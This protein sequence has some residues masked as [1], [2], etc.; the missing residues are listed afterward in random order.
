MTRVVFLSI[1]GLSGCWAGLPTNYRIA[2]IQGYTGAPPA[3][4]KLQLLAAA[5]EISD[6]YSQISNNNLTLDIVVSSIDTG[7]TVD[8]FY[9]IDSNGSA[10][11]VPTEQI[12]LG[13]LTFGAFLKDHIDF[14]AVDGIAIVNSFCSGDYAAPP[15]ALFSL[16][17]AGTYEVAHLFECA[18]DPHLTAQGPSGVF[19]GP[20]AHEIGHMLEFRSGSMMGGAWNGHPSE[21]ASGYALMD[22]SYPSSPSAYSV[23]GTSLMTSAR[24]VFNGWLPDNQVVNINSFSG[25]FAYPVRALTR[26]P[27]GPLCGLTPDCSPQQVLK[28]GITEGLYY[29]VEARQRTGI[30]TLPTTLSPGGLWD[31]GIHITLVDESADPPVTLMNSRDSLV[32]GGCDTGNGDLTVGRLEDPRHKNCVAAHA[33]SVLMAPAYCWPCPLFHV[34][35]SFRDYKN[36]IRISVIAAVPDGFSVTVDR[37]PA[38]GAPDLRV[39]PRSPVPLVPG[40]NVSGIPKSQIWIDSSCNGYASDFG[41]VALRFGDPANSQ[42]VAVGDDLCLGH[43]NR[44]YA[45]IQ[46]R[47]TAAAQNVRVHFDVGNPIAEQ[48]GCP[49]DLCPTPFREVGVADAQRFPALA[50]LAPGATATVFVPYTPAFVETGS[51]FMTTSLQV[52]IESPQNEISTGD[53]V[54]VSDFKRVEAVLGDFRLAQF[55]APD[56]VFTNNGNNIDVFPSSVGALPGGV[57]ISIGQTPPRVSL[58]PL[59]QLHVPLSFTVSRQTA[60]AA[61]QYAATVLLSAFVPL[62]GPMHRDTHTDFNTIAAHTVGIDV[63]QSSSIQL[64]TSTTRRKA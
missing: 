16:A 59:Q 49:P 28:V 51:R 56:F 26:K 23:L 15:V 24:T 41:P 9:F 4:S 14:A 54:A 2:L 12:A 33:Y 5:Q 8:K 60:P 46:N 53:N 1:L 3:Y 34:G 27:G 37:G 63:V 55:A 20:W 31:E 39:P 42:T 21:Y 29:L 62:V 13:T 38:G 58:G 57:I 52:R 36:N 40:F 64:R 7:Q 19:W 22:S 25:T 45:R 18:P 6:Y 61:G 48:G 44:L 50:S 35:D 32:A 47:G 10:S 43:E 11:P 17:T 30:D